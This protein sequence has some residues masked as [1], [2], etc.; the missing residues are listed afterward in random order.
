MIN[1]V[2]WKSDD[3]V[4]LPMLNDVVRNRFYESI[5]KSTVLGKQ[6]IDIG[7][8]TGI[9]SLLALKHGAE[10]VVAYE[11][12]QHRF[13]LAQQIVDELG[14]GNKITLINSKFDHNTP[15]EKDCVMISE[16]V[17][18]NLWSEGMFTTMPRTPGHVFLPGNYFLEL[19]V[20]PVAQDYVDTLKTIAPMH[21]FFAPGVDLDTKF[22][23]L[24][25]QL[26]GSTIAVTPVESKTGLVNY[27]Y[28]FDRPC[29]WGSSPFLHLVHEQPCQA[30]Y[31]ISITDQTMRKTDAHGTTVQPIDY[32]KRECELS[33]SVFDTPSML[34]PRVGLQH[35]DK[36][37]YLDQAES[38]GCLSPRFVYSP[39]QTVKVTHDLYHGLITY[40][41]ED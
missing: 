33:L 35:G 21:S 7:F 11:M 16:T 22:V 29:V 28:K 3:G 9:L 6:C 39:M 24:I 38:W 37:I 41:S 17:S 26:L 5:I 14:L 10:H 30:S 36:K 1:G 40:S 27:S 12:N 8:G 18:T 23:N 15:V 32:A 34:L 2:N 25:N 13:L 4:F 19:F 20:I 31:Q